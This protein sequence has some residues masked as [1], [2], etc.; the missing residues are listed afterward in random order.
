VLT[1][2]SYTF[3]LKKFPKQIVEIYQRGGAQPALVLM[4]RFYPRGSARWQEKAIEWLEKN[5]PKPEGFESAGKARVAFKVGDH[6]AVAARGAA[7]PVP[8]AQVVQVAEVL[9]DGNLLKVHD[10][11]DKKKVYYVMCDQLIPVA[12]PV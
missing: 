1:A 2:D 9:N 11:R 3:D 8:G 12:A 4:R 5:L 6:G 7:K 10:A